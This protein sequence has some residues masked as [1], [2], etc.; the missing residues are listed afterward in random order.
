MGVYIHA[1]LVG[2]AAALVM[3][4]LVGAL[5]GCISISQTCTG[6]CSADVQIN[7]NMGTATVPVGGLP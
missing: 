3:S 5:T 4:F 7:G 1:L 2:T 6:S